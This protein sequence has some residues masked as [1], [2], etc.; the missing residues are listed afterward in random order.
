MGAVTTLQFVKDL[1]NLGDLAVLLPVAIA[2]FAWLMATQTWRPAASWALALGICVGGT[3]LL[4]ILFFICPPSASLHSPS[5]HTSL[6]TLVYG[7]LTLLLATRAAAWQRIGAMAAGGALVASIA[8]SRIVLSSHTY[9][10]T[11]TGLGIGGLA[12]ALFGGIYL[13]GGRRDVSLRPLLLSVAILIV[14]LHGQ[15]LHAEDL[16]RAIGGHLRAD[17]L[18][19]Q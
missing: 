17:G 1:T 13:S 14:L 2:T 8:A 15:Q 19:C 16:F 4:K 3:G 6:S 18:A 12:L 11:V 5:G 9:L 7:G 10:E